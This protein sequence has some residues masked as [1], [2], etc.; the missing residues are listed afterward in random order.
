MFK[1]YVHFATSSYAYL[2]AGFGTLEAAQTYAR[3]YLMADAR[4]CWIE[5]PDGSVLLISGRVTR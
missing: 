4:G 3:R 2:E 5:K 1:V